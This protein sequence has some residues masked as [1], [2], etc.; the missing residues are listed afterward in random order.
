MKNRILNRIRNWCLKGLLN[1]VVLE[2]VATI[3]NGNKLFI[4][5]QEIT[6]DEAQTLLA[7]VQFIKETRF[8]KI[9]QYTLKENAH[10][11]M[12]RYAKS[13]E[14]MWAGKLL[15]YNLDIQ[16]KLINIIKGYKEK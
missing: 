11:R 1:A 4:Q 16:N 9:C 5:G 8:W 2:D 15:L 7:E 10:K 12:F 3:G 14:D 13:Y 6:P